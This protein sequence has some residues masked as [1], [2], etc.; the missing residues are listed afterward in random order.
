[1]EK[2]NIDNKL[3]FWVPLEISKAQNEQ[4]ITEMKIK[5]VA[6]TIDEDTDGE[7][8]D[9]K[10]FDLS[11]FK[12]SGF[13][14]WHHKSGTDPNMIV[15]EPTKANITKKGLEIEGMLYNDSAT[16][17]SIYTLAQ[18]LE[19]N[20]STRRLGFSIEG[21]AIERDVLNP[22]KV[23][24]ALITGCAITFLPKNPNTIMN[25]VK[26]DYQDLYMRDSDSEID[27]LFINQTNQLSKSQMFEK[28]FER[29]PD[30][31]N[32]D[33]EILLISIQNSMKNTRKTSTSEEKDFNKALDVLG[34]SSKIKKSID[35]DDED[36]EDEEIEDE[37]IDDVEDE[38]IDD[39][40]DDEDLEKAF[41]EEAELEE[42]EEEEPK[43]MKKA[44][45]KKVQK[46]ISGLD[47]IKAIEFQSH[48][49]TEMFRALGTMIKKGNDDFRA[50][51]AQNVE[52]SER[53]EKAIE[54]ITDL[55]S[56]PQNQRK[57]VKSF[58]D[59]N[60]EKGIKDDDFSKG[61][62]PADNAKTLSFARNRK[63]VLEL[64]DEAAFE[65]GYD[66]EFGV[67]LTTIEAG[68]VPSQVVLQRLRTEK[69]IT[70]T[71]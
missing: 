14:N 58:R 60:F 8:L 12:K 17:K 45:K 1:M 66:P 70:I 2:T 53:L 62:D 47:L 57:S 37:D 29:F 56:E 51:S 33:A 7:F 26:G 55:Q 20:S 41:E 61:G 22:K 44:Y 40:D 71:A 46:S 19:K 34:L 65:K 4:G 3:R 27:E 15:G 24:K 31:P 25:I 18:T 59:K 50:L 16:A 5:G 42:E 32:E 67:A 48:E 9:P 10:G 13:L 35:D 63:E 49:S 69:G 11:L 28:I 54:Y 64:L 39:E 52:L 23:T 36:L 6:S 43:K 38:D 68:G 21:K 30:L